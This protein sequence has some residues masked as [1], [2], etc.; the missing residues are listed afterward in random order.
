MAV[1]LCSH[2]VLLSPDLLPLVLSRLG[3]LRHLHSAAQTCK[4]WRRRVGAAAAALRSVRHARTLRGGLVHPFF[5]CSRPSDDALIVANVGADLVALRPAEL[6]SDDLGELGGEPGVGHY[7]VGTDAPNE[8]VLMRG[9][10]GVAADSTRLFVA[11][12]PT[13]RVLKFPMYY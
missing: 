5:L 7:G 6:A 9:P 8:V 11:D 1:E 2:P 3:S 4:F 12:M 13:S 10:A